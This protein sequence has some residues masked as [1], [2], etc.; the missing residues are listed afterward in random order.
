MK[1]SLGILLFIFAGCQNQHHENQKNPGTAIING[2]R[3]TDESPTFSKSIVALQT[4]VGDKEFNSECTASLI[5]PRTILTAAHCFDVSGTKKITS[6]QVLFETRS[7]HVQ[8]PRVAEGSAFVVHP[9]YNTI[10]FDTKIWF[11][12]PE[13]WDDKEY[14]AT[15]PSYDHDIAVATL[16]STAPRDYRPLALDYDKKAD[17]SGAK[18]LVYGFGRFIDYDGKVEVE[19]DNMGF[20]LRG[21]LQISNQFLSLPDRYFYQQ[22]SKNQNTCQGDSGGPHILVRAYRTPRIV[23]ITSAGIGKVLENGMQSCYNKKSQATRVAPFAEWIKQEEKNLLR[24]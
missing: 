16:K 14:Y 24:K 8:N 3:L 15:L 6:F 5:G 10:P 12:E 20:L 22:N 18:V 9:Q 1:K 4:F 23:G 11:D 13:L 7:M 21:E 19:A 17:H 2:D